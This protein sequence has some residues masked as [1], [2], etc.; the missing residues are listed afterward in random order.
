[1]ILTPGP[2]TV[3]A[4]LRVLGLRH[5]PHFQTY[6]RMLNRATWSSRV[7]SHLL[8]LLLLRAFVPD[9]VPV[10]LGINETIERRCRANGWSARSRGSVQAVSAGELVRA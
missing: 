4:A 6:H 1:M 8:L 2:R 7:L 3:A 9:D 5:E 10:V